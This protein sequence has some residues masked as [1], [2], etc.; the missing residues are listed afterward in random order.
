MS[1]YDDLDDDDKKNLDEICH[2]MNEIY[3]LL[4]RHNYPIPIILNALLLVARAQLKEY[5]GIE[6]EPSLLRRLCELVEDM[7]Q[8][9]PKEGER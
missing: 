9:K 4:S 1:E 7:G 8:R 6:D 5:S 3:R 2:L